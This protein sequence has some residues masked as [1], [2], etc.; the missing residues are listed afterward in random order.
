MSKKCKSVIFTQN[1]LRID[2][3]ASNICLKGMGYGQELYSVGHS[4]S[5]I[6]GW[7]AKKI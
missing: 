7:T 3:R 4:E 1:I 2:S 5:K 6:Y